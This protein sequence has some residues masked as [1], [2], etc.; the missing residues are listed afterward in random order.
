MVPQCNFE[1]SQNGKSES[2]ILIGLSTVERVA[3]GHHKGCSAMF[4]FAWSTIESAA[5]HGLGKNG[6]PG[7]FGVGPCQKFPIDNGEWAR[8]SVEIPGL[9]FFSCSLEKEELFPKS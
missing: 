5:P 4:D 7:T 1:A 3:S 9:C 6:D 8:K 2:V